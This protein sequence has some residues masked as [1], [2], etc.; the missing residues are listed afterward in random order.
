MI[1]LSLV[2]TLSAAMVIIINDGPRSPIRMNY[3]KSLFSASHQAKPPQ[4]LILLSTPLLQSKNCSERISELQRPTYSQIFRK[5]KENI[6]AAESELIT[7]RSLA[8]CHSSISPQAE[9]DQ[10]RLENAVRNGEKSARQA[11]EIAGTHRVNTTP[12]RT[13]H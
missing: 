6:P 10:L 11:E 8:L 2:R 1:L 7:L 12:I 9:T 4:S 13:M 5:R 3:L